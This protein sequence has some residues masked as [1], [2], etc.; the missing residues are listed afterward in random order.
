MRAVTQYRNG[1]TIIEMLTEEDA[2]H[3]KQPEN[4]EEFI[5]Q[6]DPK[7]TFKERAYPVIIQFAPLKF[8]PDDADQLRVL[9]HENNWEHDTITMARWVKPPNKRTN[10]QQVAHIMLTMKDPK[11]AN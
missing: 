11:S 1:G 4:K 9:E 6:L 7:A 2:T 10:H 3:L 8:D 5:K